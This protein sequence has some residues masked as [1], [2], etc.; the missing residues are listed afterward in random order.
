MEDVVDQLLETGNSVWMSSENIAVRAHKVESRG[1]VGISCTAYA[2]ESESYRSRQSDDFA[3]TDLKADV[4]NDTND[5]DDSDVQTD[6]KVR[7]VFV[8]DFLQ[9]MYAS[10]VESFRTSLISL[11]HGYMI[12][13]YQIVL[14]LSYVG[15]CSAFFGA[16]LIKNFFGCKPEGEYRTDMTS[17]STGTWYW[18]H[19]QEIFKILVQNCAI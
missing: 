15:T 13:K 5:I 1:F 19:T 10:H 12:P 4:T 9:V 17:Y 7:V 3:C 6:D 18:D 14:N 8:A 2:D 11:L 16:D